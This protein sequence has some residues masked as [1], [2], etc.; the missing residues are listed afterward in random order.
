MSKTAELIVLIITL[1][2]NET[3]NFKTDSPHMASHF[4]SENNSHIH[5]DFG[6]EILKNY[7]TFSF[8]NGSI[9]DHKTALQQNGNKCAITCNLKF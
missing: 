9:T 3:D 6:K 2:S 4:F 8:L 7:I 1:L 5:I